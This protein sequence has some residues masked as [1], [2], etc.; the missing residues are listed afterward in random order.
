MNKSLNNL[1]HNTKE[2]PKI[3][4]IIIVY[5]ADKMAIV[6]RITPNF[7]KLWKKRYINYEG[8]KWCYLSDIVKI[9]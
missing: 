2:L 6:K 3:G 8:T 1:W 9:N 7:L 4:T 5:W